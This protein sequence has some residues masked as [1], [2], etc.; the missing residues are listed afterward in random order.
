MGPFGKAV[1]P[2]VHINRFGVIPKKHQPGKWRLISD[3][4]YPEGRSVNDLITPKWCSLSYISVEQVATEALLKGKGALI[5][6]IDVKSAYRLIP[7]YPGDRK[8]LGMEINGQVYI[9]GML[10]FGLRSAPKLFNA[11]ADALE[12]CVAQEGVDSMFHYLDDFAVVGPPNSEA[13]AQYLH[14]LVR[15][16]NDLGVPLAPE[17]Q[18]GPTSVITFLGIIID[19]ERGELRLPDDKLHRLIVA[20]TTWEKR[21]TCTRRELESLIGTLQHA[22]K[23]IPAGRAFLRRAISLLSVTKQQHHHIRLNSDFRSDMAW[24][25]A[26]APHWNGASLLI[27]PG[28]R[29]IKVTSDASGR[30]G[31]GA[32]YRSSWFQLEWD[33]RSR[34]FSIAIKELIPIII[35]AVIWGEEWSG[36]RVQACCDNSAVVAIMNSRYSREN[37]MM[38][39]L[40]CLFFVETR[41]QFRISAAHI[42]G[43]HNNLAD[44]LSRNRVGAVKEKA[45]MELYPSPIHPSI[46]QWLLHPGLDWLSPSWMELFNTFAHKD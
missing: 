33:D 31:C 41:Y 11:L 19:T 10:P 35:A 20:V 40:R 3:L 28:C 9:D 37:H 43:I 24:W 2:K 1:A 21:K 8:W 14:T 12:W 34:H 36:G 17:K 5:A 30:W 32:S 4:S 25:R 15:V 6:K 39:M 7:V 23:V 26:F 44:D 22:C 18:E 45:G 38:R 42:P 29:Q 27:R 16:C 46:L 13:C